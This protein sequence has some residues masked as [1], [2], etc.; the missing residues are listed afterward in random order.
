MSLALCPQL[1]SQAPQH[2]RSSETLAACACPLLCADGTTLLPDKE[3]MLERRADF[4]TSTT[5]SIYLYEL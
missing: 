5:F 4:N 2:F 1:V 3:K